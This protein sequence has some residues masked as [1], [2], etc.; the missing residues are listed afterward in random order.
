[1]AKNEV[2][3][4]YTPFNICTIAHYAAWVK[5][6]H[7]KCDLWKYRKISNNGGRGNKRINFRKTA[8]PMNN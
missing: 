8:L 7:D 6:I 3:N 1:M 5:I 4:M 2:Y